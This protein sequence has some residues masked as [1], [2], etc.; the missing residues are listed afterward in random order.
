MI[1]L[2]YMFMLVMI[3]IERLIDAIFKKER[4]KTYVSF[5]KLLCVS[6]PSLYSISVIKMDF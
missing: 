1:A 5:L 6:F 3:P 4:S 2:F